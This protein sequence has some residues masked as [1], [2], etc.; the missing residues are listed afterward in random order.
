MSVGDL[1][2]Q[3]GE[4]AKRIYSVISGPCNESI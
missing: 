4:G 1:E 3:V 2:S